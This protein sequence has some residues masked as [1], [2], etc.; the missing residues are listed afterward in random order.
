M[1]DF[2]T[3]CL[4]SLNVFGTADRW[5]AY[6]WNAFI[7]GDGTADLETRTTKV[8]DNSVTVTS[9][10]VRYI[11]KVIDNAITPASDVVKYLVHYIDSS[12]TP[13]SDVVKYSVKVID[14]TLAPVS[15]V[16]KIIVKVMDDGFSVDSDMVVVF[17]KVLDNDLAMVADMYLESLQEPNGWYY[18]F[19]GDATNIENRVNT[20]YASRTSMAS[21]WTQVVASA[22]TWS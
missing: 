1:A 15:D 16:V 20:A 2:S 7:W 14:N 21:A 12:I 10:D 9:D 13:T 22:T 3:T 6:N 4:N 11:F 18:V 5:N 8:I 17:T 19:T